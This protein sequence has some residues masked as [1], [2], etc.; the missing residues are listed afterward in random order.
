MT[1]SQLDFPLAATK[2]AGTTCAQPVPRGANTHAPRKDTRTAAAQS[3]HE[4]R[5]SQREIVYLYVLGQGD[6]GATRKEIAANTNLSEN[7]VRP[8]VAELLDQVDP[9][10]NHVRVFETGLIADQRGGCNVLYAGPYAVAAGRRHAAS[11]GPE[12]LRIFEAARARTA[13]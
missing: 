11:I 13:A 7:S 4:R 6:R 8:R 3:N 1:E 12:A 10:T 5:P 9:S 2:A